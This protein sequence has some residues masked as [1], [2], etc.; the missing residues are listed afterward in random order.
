MGRKY[1]SYTYEEYMKAMELHHRYKLGHIRISRIL[2]IN[3]DT[4]KN[5][6]YRGVV[7][8]TAKL[9]AKPCTELA[10]VI[11]AVHGDASVSKSKHK[12]GYEYRIELATIDKEFA[13]AFSRAASK[14]LNKKYHGPWWEERRKKWWVIYQSR[15]FFMWYKKT[16]E[17]GLEGFT[18][19]IEHSRETVRY[20]LR[21]LYDSDGSNKRNKQIC[22]YNSN[23]SLLEYVQY[24]LEKYFD[25]IATG[26]Y[27]VHKAGSIMMING[28]K[29]RYNNDYYY[30][31]I[32]RKE[33]VLRFLRE[34]GFSIVR[35]QLG[36]KKHE[37]VFV[38]GRYVEPYKPVEL[39]LFK[40]PF[41]Q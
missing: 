26:P 1:K 40:L 4:V 23:N 15:A 30:I 18:S 33:H 12:Y 10:Y 37:K 14:F 38:E 19:F 9:V 20:Y 22:L 34:I 17:K 28:V 16:E 24:L 31:S 39:G 35:K 27:L 5:W 25:I 36:L 21:G 7:P 11:G 2:D 29:T 8:P 13:I 32:G 3:E 6:L 41:N